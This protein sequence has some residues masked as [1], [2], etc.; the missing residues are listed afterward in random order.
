ME[1]ELEMPE[2]DRA[3]NLD[4]GSPTESVA[5]VGGPGSGKTLL[6]QAL[7][8]TASGPPPE[9]RPGMRGLFPALTWMGEGAN[10][11][12]FTDKYTTSVFF[13]PYDPEDNKPNFMEFK[14]NQKMSQPVSYVGGMG[15]FWATSGFK[16]H[17]LGLA[18][19]R[20]KSIANTLRSLNPGS[21]WSA[22]D[23]ASS[24]SY[25]NSAT[26][27]VLSV[28]LAAA[29]MMTS[30]EHSWFVVLDVSNPG[31]RPELFADIHQHLVQLASRRSIKL[32]SFM[33]PRQLEQAEYA[34]VIHL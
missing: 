11:Q 15:N 16:Q 7:T 3:Y 18:K 20:S 25:A 12:I 9:G 29:T 4:L 32:I 14:T 1:F 30:V 10:S 28:C 2:H 8:V 13:H 26:P 31:F 5:V 21:S 17:P 19:K 27:P 33:Q 24:L 34:K 22:E 23:M 6:A